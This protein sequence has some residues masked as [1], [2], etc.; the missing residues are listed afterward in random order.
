ME[1]K[2][3]TKGSE[4]VKQYFY[5]NIAQD[6]HAMVYFHYNPTNESIDLYENDDEHIHT[7]GYKM[8]ECLESW[9]KELR[10]KEFEMLPS[11]DLPLWTLSYQY[12]KSKP[13]IIKKQNI[14]YFKSSLNQNAFNSIV[15]DKSL[16]KL[17]DLSSF[18]YFDKLVYVQNSF[19]T[20]VVDSSCDKN[21]FLTPKMIICDCPI[22]AKEFL[23]KHFIYIAVLLQ[24]CDIPHIAKDIPINEKRKRGRPA[25][26]KRALLT[27]M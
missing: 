27:Q 6:C 21:N 11:I 23:C 1:K 20:V 4:G 2:N 3:P 5:C 16:K 24:F 7:A 15:L 18:D 12:K 14:F 10:D 17:S 26:A 22:F 25:L 9:T 19:W 13:T 8:I